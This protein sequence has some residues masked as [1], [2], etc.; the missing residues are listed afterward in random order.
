MSTPK[1]QAGRLKQADVVRNVWVVVPE[2]GFSMEDIL[3][4]GY[5][6]HVAVEF[7]QY[8]RI[9]VQSEDASVWA[10]LLVVAAGPTWAKVAPVRFVELGR[11]TDI[12]ESE[13]EGLI[14]QFRG[15]IEKWCVQSKDD[16]R[17][18]FNKLESRE[19][20]T[21]AAMQHVKRVAA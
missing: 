14:V 13:Y 19:E 17:V 8:D 3:E 7:R 10:E 5:W 9:E 12:P 4:P 1:L 2:H 16:R 6:A 18:L 11:D 20:A 21:L 15:P